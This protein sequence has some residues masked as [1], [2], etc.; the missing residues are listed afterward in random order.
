MLLFHAKCS[1]ALTISGAQG[2][3]LSTALPAPLFICLFANVVLHFLPPSLC[4]VEASHGCRWPKLL[5]SSCDPHTSQP[6]STA[7]VHL[8]GRLRSCQ[9]EFTGHLQ[10]SRKCLAPF[11]RGSELGSIIG[12]QLLSSSGTL[13]LR[14]LSISLSMLDLLVQLTVGL[15]TLRFTLRL[16]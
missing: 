12:S 6:S 5:V 11:W 1:S 10:H 8:L 15:L 16:C 3:F 13:G 9:H 14:V 7:T 4:S 2:P